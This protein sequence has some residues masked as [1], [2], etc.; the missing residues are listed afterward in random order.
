MLKVYTDNK[1]TKVVQI[2]SFII[3]DIEKGVLKKDS[4]LPSINEFSEQYAVARDTIEKAY[5]ELKKEDY[6]I[7]VAGK[8]FY[9]KG[10]KDNRLKILLVFNEMTS[11]KKVLYDAFINELK[12]KATVDLQFHHY[13]PEHLTAIIERNLGNYHYY[14]VMPHFF[15][16]SK[17]EQYLKVLNQI[18]ED[19]LMF[20]DKAIPELSENVKAV[21]QDFKNDIYKALLSAKP[22]LKKYENLTFV[23]PTHTNY[24]LEVLESSCRFCKKHGFNFSKMSNQVIEEIKKGTVYLVN[25]EADLAQLIK[26][27][28]QSGFEL[29]KE[30][31]VLS[32]NETVMKEFLDI[33]VVTTDFELMGQCA[34]KM[35]LKRENRRVINPYRLILR[36]SV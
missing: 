12:D 29:G 35:L 17:K 23:F 34:A 28:R 33:T 15:H 18:P 20:L 26:K 25:V 4:R 5:K 14:V 11:Y 2:V 16:K 32:F 36:K 13:N 1:V 31:G 24:P 30:V 22:L 7:S 3:K 8:G 10:K 6:I 19:E 27:I 9:V 21:Y